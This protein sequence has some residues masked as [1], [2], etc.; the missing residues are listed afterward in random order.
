MHSSTGQ[1]NHLKSMILLLSLLTD[2]QLLTS[3]MDMFVF[4]RFM[5]VLASN[6]PHHFDVAVNDRMD[7]MVE[8][9]LPGSAEREQML[10]HY[11]NQFVLETNMMGWL[12]KQRSTQQYCNSCAAITS[13]LGKS[14]WKKLI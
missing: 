9:Q 2:D 7:D 8:F 6:Q 3:M 4:L 1:V 5:L 13:D 14:S 12:R 10:Q 11:Y